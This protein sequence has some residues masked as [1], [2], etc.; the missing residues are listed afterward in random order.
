M[1]NNNMLVLV[2]ILAIL[3]AMYLDIR[4]VKKQ[5]IVVTSELSNVRR[6]QKLEH[7]FVLDRI[8]YLKNITGKLTRTFCKGSVTSF[9][10]ANYDYVADITVKHIE[11]QEALISKEFH[12]CR[13]WDLMISFDCPKPSQAYDG[14]IRAPLREGDSVVSYGFN[15]H[16]RG[17]TGVLGGP[18]ETI[19]EVPIRPF[20]GMAEINAGEYVSYGDQLPGHSGALVIN[21]VGAVGMAHTRNRDDRTVGIVPITEVDNCFKELVSKNLL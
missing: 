6:N 5:M 17:W 18:Y 12:S 7:E 20:N 14:R 10:Y 9:A 21:S 8:G 16:M 3:I 13:G 11:C 1:M 19:R 4:D 2:L 15:P